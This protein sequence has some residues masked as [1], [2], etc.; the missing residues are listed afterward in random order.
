MALFGTFLTFSPL[1]ASAA[2]PE[3]GDFM[4]AVVAILSSLSLLPI[5]AT[6]VNIMMTASGREMESHGVKF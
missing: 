3:M 5:I 2:V 6:L 1:G 4:R